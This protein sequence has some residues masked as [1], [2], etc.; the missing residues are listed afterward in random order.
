MRSRIIVI[1]ALMICAT[2][3][4]SQRPK[5]DLRAYAGYHTHIF[6]YKEAPKSKDILHGWQ[7]GFGFRVSYRRLMAEVDLNFSRDRVIIPVPDSINSEI[8]TGQ[9]KLYSLDLPIK[10]GVIPIKTGFF[11][12]YLYTGIAL[13]LNGK[14]KY[15]FGD[16]E[17]KFKAKDLGLSNPNVDF[18][19][20]TQVDIGVL[21]LELSYKFGINNALRE[22]IR[23]NSHK[24]QFNVG[25]WF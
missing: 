17:E 2:F 25:I 18:L 12:W 4:F 16:I 6:V 15:T 13:R 20:G 19:F 3:A 7:G 1:L 11:K 24:I 23:T 14:G 5:L 22:D 10:V 8:E 21:N 9:I